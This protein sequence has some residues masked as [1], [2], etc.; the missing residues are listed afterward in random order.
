MRRLLVVVVGALGGLGLLAFGTAAL[1]G[2]GA[3]V[4]RTATTPEEACAER[5]NQAGADGLQTSAPR[6]TVAVDRTVQFGLRDRL[7]VGRRRVRA[8]IVPPRN[9]A[10][11]AP[12]STLSGAAWTFV[13]VRTEEPGVYRVD[14][15]DEHGAPL[16]CDAFLVR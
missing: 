11:A 4:D 1:D 8:E 5:R 14:W 7:G 16:A 10:V 13:D 12:M 2:R 6:R 3:V 9:E 15:L